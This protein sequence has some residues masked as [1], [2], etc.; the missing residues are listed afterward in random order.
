MNFDISK[1][2]AWVDLLIKAEVHAFLLILAGGALVLTGHK[3]EGMLILGAAVAVFKG[4][5]RT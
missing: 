4:G 3:D 2:T 5:G 1:S